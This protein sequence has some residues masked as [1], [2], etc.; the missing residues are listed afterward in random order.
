MSS[1]DIEVVDDEAL[2]S[3]LSN[4]CPCDAVSCSRFIFVFGSSPVS[5]NRCSISNSSSYTGIAP[6]STAGS[7]YL[8]VVQSPSG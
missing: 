3:N 2:C 8:A 4:V 5:F 7:K 6:S 1:R